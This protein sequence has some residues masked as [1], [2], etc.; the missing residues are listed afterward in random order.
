[1]GKNGTIDWCCMP[2]FDSPSVFG[3]IIDASKGGFYSI[4]PKNISENLVKQY[5]LPETNILVTRFLSNDGVAEVTDFMPI[6]FSKVKTQHHRLM[7]GVRVVHGAVDIEM[8]C[9]P[10]FNYARDKHTVELSKKGALFR[11][12]SL[13][14]GSYSFNSSRERRYE[15]ASTR[16]LPW[17]KMNGRIFCL[18]ALIRKI[19]SSHK[20]LVES[21]KMDLPR[22]R[23]IGEPGC[24]SAGIRVGGE[25]TFI[26]P[27]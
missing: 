1:M 26:D 17:R 23:H 11:G 15:V 27:L 22:P 14:F 13:H 7:R 19:L 20:D 18:R 24:S 3:Q 12:K 4:A 6:Q 5:Y 16:R 9:R 25:N 21:S 10:A 2:S 8:T